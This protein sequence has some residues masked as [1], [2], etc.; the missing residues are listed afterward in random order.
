MSLQHVQPVHVAAY[1]EGLL[2]RLSAPTVKQ[3]LAGL[4]MLFDWLVVGQIMP[5]NPA[6][7]V[8]GP[9]HF[10]MKGKTPV[11]NKCQGVT[12]FPPRSY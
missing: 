12:I 7:V 6:S 1:V 9:K 11:K 10:V 2:L 3:R 4:R 5:S 8:H